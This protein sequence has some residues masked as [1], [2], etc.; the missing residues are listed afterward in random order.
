M[1]VSRKLCNFCPLVL[2]ILVPEMAKVR[3]FET[4]M[5]EAK[6]QGHNAQVLSKKK[7]FAE[8]HRKF[9][10]KFTRSQKKKGFRNVSARSLARSKTKNKYSHDLGPF[11][12]NQKIVLSSSHGLQIMFLRTPPLLSM[13]LFVSGCY[14]N[15]LCKSHFIVCS[16]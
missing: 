13:V 2:I 1:I 11:S 10:R 14:R 4:G 12:A 7:V 16:W 15:L 3:L 6:D 9:S 5:L 8:K